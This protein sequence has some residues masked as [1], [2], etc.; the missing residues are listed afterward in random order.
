MGGS[1]I[2]T[3]TAARAQAAGAAFMLMLLGSAGL[4]LR[5]PG[6]MSDSE[7]ARRRKVSV[8]MVL[9]ELSETAA[10]ALVL[11]VGGSDER[12]RMDMVDVVG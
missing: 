8:S 3:L 1:A 2:R 6:R 4:N 11:F 12:R 9:W 7:D 5:R 10:V